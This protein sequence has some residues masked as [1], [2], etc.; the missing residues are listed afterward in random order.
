[1]LRTNVLEL[2]SDSCGEK[3]LE[4]KTY[5]SLNSTKQIKMGAIMSYITILFNIVVGLVY[6]PWMIQKIGLSE[7]GLYSLALT[8]ISFFA[9]DFGLGEAVS[10]FLSKYNI[11][12]EN[13]K[14]RDFLGITFKIYIIIDIL[15]FLALVTILIFADLIYVKLTPDELLKFR[16][17]FGI[18]ALY[19]IA[20]FPFMPLNGVLISYERFV[21]LKL[22]DLFNKV[23]TTT[24]MVI[25]LLLGNELY[26]LVIVNA[27]MG[28]LTIGIKLKYIFKN[29]L[30]EINFKSKDKTLL[31]EIFSFSMWTAIIA[32]AQRFILN[33]TPTVLAA[34]A[35][36]VQIT[37][38][39]ISI[40]IEGYIWTFANALNGLFLPKVTRMSIKNDNPL[41]IENLM[42]RVGR[43]QL[44]IVGL[45]IIGFFTMGKEFM[46]LWMG[47][48][49]L[50]SYYV[51]ILLIAPCIITLTQQ[52]GNT[53]LIAFNEIKYR[54]ICS[55]IVAVVSIVL[56]ILFSRQWGAIG[57][58]FAIF[59]GNCIGLIIGM[60]IIYYKVLKINI[61]RFFKECH[62][63]M[64]VPLI[65]TI[66]F[67]VLM[68]YI[69][70]VENLILFIIKVL[71]FSIIYLLLMWFLALNISEKNLFMG[72]F[73]KIIQI[74]RRKL[75]V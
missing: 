16:I 52:I 54:A 60:N 20:S 34:F 46:V 72:L 74:F 67:G 29:K 4:T 42:I 24:T 45:L 75:N 39:S 56:S 58:G 35:G 71:I 49:F 48:N 28:I 63:K 25:V 61:F 32:V 14:K 19:S 44:F 55:L 7:Y 10:R 62:M 13:N 26:S 31:K 9:I 12:Y 47:K 53:A 65:L 6:T 64:S 18:A 37:L 33:I 36:S 1:M 30:L 27:I 38:F 22:A 57:S 40:I 21:F 2:N 50:D 15:I 11:E 69:F 8:L 23:L 70:P 17:V 73:N 5:S 59:V 41:E 66:I 43:L 51:T 3:I 68:Q